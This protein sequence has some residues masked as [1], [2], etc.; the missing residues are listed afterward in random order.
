MVSAAPS[1]LDGVRIDMRWWRKR[2]S[3]DWSKHHL[4]WPD[5]NTTLCGRPVPFAA[6][7]S[8]E[9][10][11]PQGPPSLLC[12]VCVQHFLDAHDAGIKEDEDA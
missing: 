4:A 1:W 7:L 11:P 2:R 10:W 9:T 3:A 5:W 12:E 6:L 8:T